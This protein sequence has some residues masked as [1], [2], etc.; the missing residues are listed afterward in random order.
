[1]KIASLMRVLVLGGAG[2]MG[3]AVAALLKLQ[4]EVI[5]GI[6]YPNEQRVPA[7]ASTSAANDGSC[8]SSSCS[9]QAWAPAA[10]RIDVVLNFVGILR[11]RGAE[12]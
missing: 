2:F 6:R 5:I 4:H 9:P 11:Q 3:H 1:M 12:T 8:D 10:C 7:R